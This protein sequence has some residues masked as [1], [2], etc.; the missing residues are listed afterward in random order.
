MEAFNTGK[1]GQVSA[2]Y[3]V[4]LAITI[5]VTVVA[6]GV[7]S[8]F[9]KTGTAS[10]TQKKGDTYWKSAA[11]GIIDWKIYQTRGT[12]NP[13]NSTL[14][15]QNNVD[16]QVTID[17]I[18]IDAGATTYPVGVTLLPGDHYSFVTPYISCTSGGSYS[19]DVTFQYDSKEQKV[20]RK[21]F[22]GAEKLAGSCSN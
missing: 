9:I 21:R 7:L 3:L 19:F 12:A 8:G 15:L 14:V 4:L 22:K 20:L 18:S 17:W 16:R 11:I 13:L 5:V 2:E 1:T 10:N 6:A